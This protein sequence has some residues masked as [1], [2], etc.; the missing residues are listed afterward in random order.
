VQ[1]GPTI[2]FQV[3]DPP[4]LSDQVFFSFGLG[5]LKYVSYEVTSPTA[6]TAIVGGQGDGADRFLLERNN[7]GGEAAWGRTEKLVSR[8]GNDPTADLQSAGDDELNDDAETARLPTSTGDTPSQRYG[9]DYD[10]GCLV[11]V[12]S[13]PGSLVSD[14]VNTVH[15]QVWPT[16]GEVVSATIGSQAET[17]DPVWLQ[18]L[19]SIDKRVGYLERNVLP[20]TT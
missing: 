6:T 7:A 14:I 20:A 19:R 3:Y 17:S 11:S 18:R 9:V 12:E 2:E 16:A 4:D 1:V 5:N 13:W 15:L 10:L 8:P